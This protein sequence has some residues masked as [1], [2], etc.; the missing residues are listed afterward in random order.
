M[1]IIF[2]PVEWSIALCFILWPVLQISIS[3]ICL[4]VPDTF[5]KKDIFLFRTLK[6]ERKGK[7]YDTIFKIRKWKRFLP[8][9]AAI[10]KSGFQKKHLEQMSSEY[11]KKYLVESRRAELG[12]WLAILPFWIFGLFTPFPVIIYMFLYAI[13]INLPCILAQRYNRPRFLEVLKKIEERE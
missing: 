6:W 11:I 4:F 1:Q 10:V 3:T 7:F 12:H 13:I 5:Y 8:D 2:L 9:G